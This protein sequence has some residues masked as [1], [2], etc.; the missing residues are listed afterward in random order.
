VA[1]WSGMRGAVSLA[2]ALALPLT[3]NTGQPFPSGT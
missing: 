3:T 2:A 1:G